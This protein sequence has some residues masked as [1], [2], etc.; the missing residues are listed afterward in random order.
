MDGRKDALHSLLA[1]EGD[2]RKVASKVQNEAVTLFTKKDDHFEGL[3]KVYEA[4]NDDDATRTNNTDRK[5]LVTTVAD[6][7]NY[8]KKAMSKG[9]NAQISKEET[10]SSGNAKEV[11][12]VGDVTFGELSAT[13]L[14]SLEKEIV[15]IRKMYA[16]IPT[17]DP[18]KHW[19]R[20]EDE[21]GMRFKTEPQ[22]TFR[23]SKDSDWVIVAP[24]TKE[25]PAQVKQVTKDTTVGNYLVT[26]TSGKITPLMK[27]QL[28]ERVD[29]LL[30]AVKS[31]RSKANQA[32]VVR[33]Y[34]GSSIFEYINKGLI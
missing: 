9:I 19:Q 25:F 4:F 30:L 5:E 1:V 31:A 27:S 33:S 14:L 18:A 22:K 17:L 6:K 23:T 12:R 10:N 16:T 7:L 13:S 20:D 21:E 11:L 8:V 24:A 15:N 34:V 3:V 32:E 28:L 29:D 26:Y 2:L